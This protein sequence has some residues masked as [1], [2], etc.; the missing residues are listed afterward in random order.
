MQK[1]MI[2]DESAVRRALNRISHEI[3]E[4]NRGAS[5]VV[6]VGIRT[7]GYPLAVRIAEKIR[8]VENTVVPVGV[9]DITHYRDDLSRNTLPEKSETDISFS[10][11]DKIVILVDDVLYTGRTIRAAIDAIFDIGRP[12]RIQVAALID[13]GHRE[14]PISAD[15]I[16][17]NIPTS[18]TEK[19]SA[20]LKEVDGQDEVCLSR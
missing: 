16:G 4:K 9:L 15:Y 3:L 13:R 18:K 1:S 12:R 2:L 14:L 19:V 10:V 7:R 5:D 11:E 8:E 6:L 20:C 17:K